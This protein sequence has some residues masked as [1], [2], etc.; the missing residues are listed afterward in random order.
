LPVWSTGNHT[1]RQR[2][3]VY[4]KPISLGR[5]RVWNPGDYHTG[6]QFK[7]LP[8]RTGPSRLRHYA[9]SALIRH[10]SRLG[11]ITT[12]STVCN[13]NSSLEVNWIGTIPTTVWPRRITTNRYRLRKN[14]HA[15][16][17]QCRLPQ[18]RQTTQEQDRQRAD[19][20]E[21]KNR[22]CNYKTAQE[23]QSRR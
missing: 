8:S 1:L 4:F 12:S 3:S 16:T 5:T 9:L 6:L 17:R 14:P 19:I 15:S 10:A 7:K 18:I 21:G 11:G 20:R 23:L 2:K 13:T 22:T